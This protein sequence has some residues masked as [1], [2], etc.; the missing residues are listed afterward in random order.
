MR[1][2][3]EDD[4]MEGAQGDILNAVEVYGFVGWVVTIAAYVSYLLWAL[5]PDE[6][7]ASV[8]MTYYPSRW[9]AVALPAWFVVTCCCILVAYIGLNLVRTPPLSSLDTLTDPM[10][11]RL[12][13]TMQWRDVN[14]EGTPGFSDMP[15]AVV[16][17]LL[18][19]PP[20]FTVTPDAHVVPVHA[21]GAFSSLAPSS[22]ASG[23]SE[24]VGAKARAMVRAR[25]ED[26]GSLDAAVP[27]S[28]PLPRVL[29]PAASP[30]AHAA[31]ANWGGGLSLNVRIPVGTLPSALV[32]D[33][34][35]AQSPTTPAHFW[36]SPRL[37]SRRTASSA[38][39]ATL[40]PPRASPGIHGRA[41]AVK[42]EPA[43]AVGVSGTALGGDGLVLP[44]L[45]RRE[46]EVDL[47][48]EGARFTL[49]ARRPRA[50]SLDL[51]FDQDAA[52][53]TG[54]VPAR[55]PYPHQVTRAPSPPTIPQHRTSTTRSRART[56][57]QATLLS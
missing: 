24:S 33:E 30:A 5:L 6:A 27:V 34:V 16:N 2:M 49:P 36:G 17:R 20:T 28:R 54:R 7:L 48:T 3:V 18:F 46:S 40:T 45:S 22:S 41:V 11:R 39:A 9:W 42:H 52:L 21:A 56:E 47:A 35:A 19:P 44:A 53:F 29:R 50:R 55:S 38:G 8:G 15:L 57:P 32:T 25:A 1:G 12:P 31:A 10:A 14:A 4:A 51:S 23:R 43:A 13:G 26:G 37:R